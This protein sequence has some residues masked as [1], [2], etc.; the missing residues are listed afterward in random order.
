MGF[1][2]RWNVS[3]VCSTLSTIAGEVNSRYNDGFIQWH[4][5]QDLYHIQIYLEELLAK[6]PRFSGEEEFLEELEKAKLWNTL[7]DKN[8]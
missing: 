2:K 1:K 7:K 5:K 8:V 6:M 4:C 3:E